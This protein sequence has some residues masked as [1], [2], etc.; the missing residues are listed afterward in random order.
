MEHD[1]GKRSGE[2]GK[3]NGLGLRRKLFLRNA[4]DNWV[5]AKRQE[6]CKRPDRRGLGLEHF[7]NLETKALAG[8]FVGKMRLNLHVHGRLFECRLDAKVV[9][10]GETCHAEN[11]QRVVA[12]GLFGIAGCAD[13]AVFQVADARAAKVLDRIVVDV[14]EERIDRQIA[15]VGVLPWGPNLDGR[16]AAVLGILLGAQVV[17]VN[18]LPVQLEGC[19]LEVLRL[20]GGAVDH[21]NRVDVLALG[22]E[23]AIDVLRKVDAHHVVEGKVNVVR[24][25]AAQLVADPAASNAHSSAEIEAGN[26]LAARLKDGLLNRRQLDAPRG[27]GIGDPHR[28]RPGVDA[29]G[30]AVVSGCSGHVSPQRQRQRRSLLQTPPGC[31]LPQMPK[32]ARARDAVCARCKQPQRWLQPQKCTAAAPPP[33]AAPSQCLLHC[34]VEREPQVI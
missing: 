9:A 20:L 17:H 18:L 11:A 31:A 7:V 8:D 10:P 6:H 1:F 24:V 34:C 27:N 30:C 25:G 2:D 29:G 16:D 26:G 5:E 32:T 12:K 13:N 19:N 22:L 28:G 4:K 14:V 33:V 15:A 3:G 23:M 21:A